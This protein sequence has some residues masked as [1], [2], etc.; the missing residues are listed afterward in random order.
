MASLRGTTQD[1]QRSDNGVVGANS[2]SVI[3]AFPTKDVSSA[4]LTGPLVWSGQ[5]FQGDQTYTLRL[6]DEE[7]GEVESAL[8]SFKALGLDGDEVS[9]DNFPLPNLSRRLRAS[10]ETLHLGRGFVVIRGIHGSKY[11]VEDSVTIFL[12]VA[13]YIADKRGL[14][15]RKGNM[16]SHITDSKEWTTPAYARHGIHT[17]GSLFAIQPFHTDMGCD[18]LSLQVRDSA[19]KGGNTYLSSSWTVFNKLLDREPEVIKTLLTPNWPVQLSGRKA[20][21]YLAPVLTFHDGKLLISLD[22]HRLGPHPIWTNGVPAL[23]EVQLNALKAVSDAASEVELQLKLETGDLL[24]FN[25][26]AL[27]HRRDAYTDDDKSARHMVRLWLRSQKYGWAI[28]DGLL[29]PWEAAYGEKRKHKT[30]HYPIVPMPEYTA[31]KYTTN[32][33][34]FVME[35]SESSDEE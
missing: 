22:P 20:T 13:S 31:P 6:S 24:F 1:M 33:A 2:E 34:C 5:D 28:P 23:T 16:L 15:D 4:A 19:N 3:G 26:L 10:A 9:A 17:K 29:P 35:D 12:G 11:T 7:A 30:R 21:F 8:A 25:N 14:Q 18:I 32:S 27:V